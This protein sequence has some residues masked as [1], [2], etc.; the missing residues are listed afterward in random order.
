MQTVPPKMLK[1][2]ELAM[3]ENGSS[4]TSVAIYIHSLRTIVNMAKDAN[5]IT[6]DQYPFGQMSK[7][8]Y[9]LV[10]I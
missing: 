10:V 8:K 9:L 5:I 1:Y 6:Q 3:T 7:K 4:I 2:Y